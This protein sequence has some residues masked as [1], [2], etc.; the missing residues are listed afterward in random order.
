MLYLLLSLLLSLLLL[1]PSLSYSQALDRAHINY[2]NPLE[3]GS[4]CTDATLNAALTAIGSAQATLMVTK[5]DRAKVACTWILANNVTVPANVKLWIPQGVAVSINNAIVLT[6]N[7]PFEADN[8]NWYSGAGTVLFNNVPWSE[9]ATANS[10]FSSYVRNGGFHATSVNL[11]SPAFS[12]RALVG[13]VD[14]NQTA[15]AITYVAAA[16]DVC[17]TI[18]SN[19]TDGITSW[20]RQGTTAYYFLCEGDTTPTQPTLPAN[21]AFLMQVT[22]TGSAIAAVSDIAL[23][24]VV[25]IESMTTSRTTGPLSYWVFQPGSCLNISS[26][27]TWTHNG[28]LTADHNQAIFCGAGS[29]AFPRHQTVYPQWWGGDPTGVVDSAGA[30]NKAIA[31]G[32]NHVN[33][34]GIWGVA[35]PIFLSKDG[36]V[37]DG[38]ARVRSQICPLAVNISSG[39]SAN[40]IIIP[41]VNVFN[42]TIKSFRFPACAVAYTGWSI[43]AVDGGPVGEQA[44]ISGHVYDIWSSPG[45]LAAGFFTGGMVNSW[46]HHIQFEDMK[47]R[48]QSVGGFSY[49]L[50]TD[51]DDLENFDPFID[52]SGG[53]AT[54]TVANIV[55]ANINATSHRRDFFFKLKEAVDV[56]ISNINYTY[57][58]AGLNLTTGLLSSELGARINLTGFS[59]HRE[60]AATGT[61][62]AFLLTNT[63]ADISHGTILNPANGT[64]ITIA[65][66]TGAT[67]VH[68][69]N[70]TVKGAL[71][72]QIAVGAAAA[73]TVVVNDSYFDISQGYIATLTG[74][75]NITFSNNRL[76][77]ANYNV[78]AAVPMFSSDSSGA[79][80]FSNNL[81]G[82]NDATSNN[83]AVFLMTGT[84]PW[85][86]NN[87][88]IIGYIEA[89][90]IGGGAT[91]EP[92]LFPGNTYIRTG[93]NLVEW[94]RNSN[95]TPVGAVVPKYLGEVY[96]DSVT[97]KWWK[98]IGFTD[99]DWVA[100]N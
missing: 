44:L 14:V 71:V 5:T 53:T 48:F 81:I 55:V 77:N 22:I 1:L 99:T 64:P 80:S 92:T 72:S 85:R 87:N 67:E 84:G 16:N 11:V 31:S 73:G 21:S 96:F 88:R 35:S 89:E 93:S 19:D 33:M 38:V 42:G 56:K 9:A 65:G 24:V 49:S 27:Q 58:D 28:K 30:I 66:T 4:G 17:W 39:G 3:Y 69:D 12:T 59:M 75:L 70:L 57:D 43:S 47:T 79:V 15:T 8:V 32:A 7:G 40:A 50:I 41:T 76:L 83:T 46:F 98:A 86:L 37:L 63:H 95:V 52:A 26:G 78:A 23:H 74:P 68:L 2:I 97:T 62:N 18:I 82:F 51:I 20:T 36:T 94:N 13:G 45:T 54:G 90:L 60:T 100:L 29:V 25:G 91:Q 10:L 6:V 61:W 34:L